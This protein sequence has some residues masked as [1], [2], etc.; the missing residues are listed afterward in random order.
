MQR[1][2]SV[3]NDYEDGIRLHAINRAVGLQKHS[4]IDNLS[5]L[6]KGMAY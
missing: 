4:L 2:E 3:E 5:F 1:G 6:T